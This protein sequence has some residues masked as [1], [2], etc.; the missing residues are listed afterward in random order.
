M[1]LMKTLGRVA[2]GVILAKGIGA[3]MQQH[4]QGRPGQV[5]RNRSQGGLL[6]ELFGNNT[7]T[8]TGGGGLNDML[9]QVLGGRGTGQGTPYGGPQSRGASGGLGG[10][11]DGLTSRARTGGTGGGGLGD[12]LG[13][14]GGGPKTRSAGTG[15]GLGDLLGGLL[16]GAAAGGMAGS[17]ARKDSQ[18]TNDASFGELF[19][20]AVVK[21]GEPEVAPTP[22]QNAVA[23]LMLR[24]MIQAAK[25]DGTI[26]DAEKQRLLG[27]LG[28]DLDDEERQFIRT[29]MAAPI[30]PEALARDVPAGLESQVYLMSL[31]AIDLD[32]DDEVRYLGRLA[33]ALKLD[34]PAIDEIHSQVGVANP[35]A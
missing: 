34:R 29:Q 1:S 31:L 20:D 22:E 24:A 10:L 35:N 32:H 28:D 9:G 16:G 6:G 2:A 7:G 26:D 27:K 17:L 12:L 5:T 11:L 25:S 33:Q 30:D 3:A 15:G 13:Q 18:P 14:L 8:R 19:N 4:Q 21:Q 23:G